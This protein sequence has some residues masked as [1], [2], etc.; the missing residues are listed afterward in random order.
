LAPTAHPVAVPMGP[1]ETV[2]RFYDRLGRGDYEAVVSLW[3]DRMKATVPS[4]PRQLQ[5]RPGSYQL[6]VQ[7]AELVSLDEGAGGAVVSVEVLEVV[8][9]F[10]PRQRRYVGTWDLV[11][12]PAGWLLDRPSLSIE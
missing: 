5:A 3:S 8:E 2:A 6:T 10:L 1:A 11:R 4:D 9:Q 12:G 7:R